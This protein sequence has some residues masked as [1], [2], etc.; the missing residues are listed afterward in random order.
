MCQYFNVGFIILTSLSLNE[1]LH[2]VTT[3]LR[4]T[5]SNLFSH[6]SSQECQIDLSSHIYPPSSFIPPTLACPSSSPS[7]RQASDRF[8]HFL[9][10]RTD[11]TSRKDRASSSFPL[12]DEGATYLRKFGC[13]ARN[14][15]IYARTDIYIYIYRLSGERRERG[16]GNIVR[17]TENIRDFSLWSFVRNGLSFPCTLMIDEPLFTRSN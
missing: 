5:F 2:N 3:I 12:S 10:P 16:R 17:R 14:V 4:K 9:I 8:G 15:E 13:H 6:F 11:N 7:R 1:N